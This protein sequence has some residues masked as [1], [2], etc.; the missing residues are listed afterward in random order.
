MDNPTSTALGWNS[1]KA[2]QSIPMKFRLSGNQGPGVL[3]KAPRVT[4][5][6][7]WKTQST[8]TGK[9]YR[10]DMELKDGIHHEAYFKFTR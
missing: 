3:N 5:D 9:C 2:G 4:Q 7:V 6:L 1:A 8:Y 10:F